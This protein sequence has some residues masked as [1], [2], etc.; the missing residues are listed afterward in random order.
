[1]VKKHGNQTRAFKFENMCSKSMDGKNALIGRLKTPKHVVVF[2]FSLLNTTKFPAF[3]LFTAKNI[4]FAKRHKGNQN[5]LCRL[6]DPG[7][8]KYAQGIYVFN[9]L[10]EFANPLP[11]MHLFDAPFMVA[12]ARFILAKTISLGFQRE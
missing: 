2:C 9:I 5:C 3:C 11:T 12:N 7:I 4:L 10:F 1:M 6:E 8:P